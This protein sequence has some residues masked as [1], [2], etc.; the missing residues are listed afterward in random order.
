M[1][2]HKLHARKCITFTPYINAVSHCAQ[3]NYYDYGLDKALLNN[4]LTTPTITDI[5]NNLPTTR[6]CRQ[7]HWHINEWTDNTDNYTHFVLDYALCSWWCSR[8]HA[9]HINYLVYR[10]EPPSAIN[11]REHITWWWFWRRVY[12]CILRLWLKDNISYIS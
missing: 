1:T 4:A 9:D 3:S 2:P 10:S 8:F 7:T 12:H 6:E 5:L 11:L